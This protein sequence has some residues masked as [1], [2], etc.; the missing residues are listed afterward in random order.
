MKGYIGRTE[1][2]LYVKVDKIKTEDEKWRLI[3]ILSDYPIE[4]PSSKIQE[5]VG[6]GVKIPYVFR[7]EWDFDDAVSIF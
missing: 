3:R 7:G 5:M 4:D 2:G 1:N 6:K